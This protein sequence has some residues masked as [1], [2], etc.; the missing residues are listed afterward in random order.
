MAQQEILLESGT[1]ELEILEFYIEDIADDVCRGRDCLEDDAGNGDRAPKKVRHSFGANV[2]KVIQVIESPELSHPESAEHPS[3]LGT[4]PL[5]DIVLPVIDLSVWLGLEKN[6]TAHE[7]IIVTEFSKTLTG[8]LVSDVVEIHR[9]A[10]TDVEPP[11]GYLT[12]MD[13]SCIVGIAKIE[14]HFVQLVDLEYIIAD[15]SPDGDMAAGGGVVASQQY[16][17]LVADDSA[18][19][20]KVMQDTLEAANFKLQVVNNGRDGLSYLMD[21]KKQ[22]EEQGESLD[23]LVNVVISD[24]EMPQM[25]GFT[26]TKNIKDDVTLRELPVILYSSIITPELQHKGESV[27]ASAQV[28]KPDL[29]LVP[30]KAIEL[31]EGV[32]APS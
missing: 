28:S 5:R 29:A 2:A 23:S 7:I 6:P 19:I 22:V 31:I 27:G 26:L 1:N 25:D 12:Q 9:V 24:I 10:W 20:R 14:N 18:I 3:Y 32:V 11:S 16:K 30:Q 21:V 8:F 17:A 13:A 4:I 15:L